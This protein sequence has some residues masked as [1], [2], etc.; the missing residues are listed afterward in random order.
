MRVLTPEAEEERADFTR[1]AH[2]VGG[3]SCFIRPPCDFCMHPGNPANQEEGE[4]AW[5]E[6]AEVVA[7]EAELAEMFGIEFEKGK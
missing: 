4:T 6:V 7:T 2:R 3:C 5:I 1:F